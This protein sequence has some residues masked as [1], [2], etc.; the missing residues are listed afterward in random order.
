MPTNDFLAER[1]RVIHHALAAVAHLNDRSVVLKG[2][3]RLRAYWKPYRYSE[4]L[5]FDHVTADADGAHR[6][7][8]LI[9]R[10]LPAAASSASI[11]LAPQVRTRGRRAILW[12]N[13]RGLSGAIKVDYRHY[14]PVDAYWAETEAG[15][16]LG[17][18]PDLPA[19]PPMRI[20]TLEQVTADKFRCLSSWRRAKSR[21][22]YDLDQLL[23]SGEVDLDRAIA[24]YLADWSDPEN[25]L[26]RNR[27]IAPDEITTAALS[28]LAEMDRD[29]RDSVMGGLFPGQD[30]DG[31]ED[32]L[33]RVAERVETLIARTPGALPP[34]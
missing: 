12:D 21:D 2:G 13:G 3:T 30:L 26:D 19:C 20:R 23:S 33:L 25:R 6:F 11:R 32:M 24:N 27:A 17:N 16:L 14:Y 1:D 4:D 31:F 18:H 5:D 34:P 10:I 22:F 29:W 9:E 15:S 8:P 28:S 7:W